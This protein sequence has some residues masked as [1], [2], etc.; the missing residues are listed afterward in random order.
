[1]F[2][3]DCE[4]ETFNFCFPVWILEPEDGDEEQT[5]PWFPTAGGGG[6]EEEDEEEEKIILDPEHVSITSPPRTTLLS[7]EHV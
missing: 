5:P 6:E 4:F 7:P 3:V 2:K 1:M